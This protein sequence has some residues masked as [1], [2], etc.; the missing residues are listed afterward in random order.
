MPIVGRVLDPDGKAL[1]A[2]KI[3]VRNSHWFNRGDESRA[4]EQPGVAGPDGRFLI[5]LNPT[6]SDAPI[7]DGPPWHEALIAAVVPGY[8]P[9]WIKAGEAAQGG[10]ELRLVRDDLP[11]R[12]RFL[13]TQGRPIAN[14]TVRV[15]WIAATL[16]GVD[17]DAL[18]ASGKLDWDG[19]TA[20]TI[21]HPRGHARSGS[22]G[23][24]PRQ[25]TPKAGSRSAAW[26][27]TLRPS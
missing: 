11:I 5:D 8:G 2:A 25:P 24:G 6:K 7:G 4:V 3:Y 19:I 26:A 27:G 17:R 21:R 12:G 13:D 22:A 23:T 9:A 16:D 20:P 10:A 14:A 1:P 18:L 15:E